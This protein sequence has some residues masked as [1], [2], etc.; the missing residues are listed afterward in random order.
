MYHALKQMGKLDGWSS[1]YALWEMPRD[2]AMAREAA[3][4]GDGVSVRGDRGVYGEGEG[5]CVGV[6]VERWIVSMGSESVEM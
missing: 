2:T 5:T 4:E 1:R 6:G 3:R